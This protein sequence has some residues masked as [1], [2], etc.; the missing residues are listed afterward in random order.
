MEILWHH[1]ICR[2]RMKRPR[3]F[4]AVSCIVILVGLVSCSK[5]ETLEPYSSS[6]T[7][8]QPSVE[9]TGGLES[10]HTPLPITLPTPGLTGTP[11]VS[12][13]LPTATQSVVLSSSAT[14][15]STLVDWQAL[16]VIPALS[17]TA[18]QIYQL[19][20]TYHNNPNAFS[21]VGDC[22]TSSAYFLADFD[23]GSNAYNLGSYQDLQS[24][25]DYFSGSFGRVSLAAGK[26]YKAASVLNPLFADS[27]Q[28]HGDESPLICEYRLQKPS[29]AF[30]M[31]GTNDFSNSRT[32]F[33]GYMRQIIEYSIKNGVV[34]ILVTKADN[35]EGDN[36]INPLIAQLAIEYDVPLWNFW[37]AVQSI[38][39]QG[40]EADGAHLT[41]SK[42]NF[43]DPEAFQF[44]FPIRNLTALQVL[45][46]LLQGAQLIS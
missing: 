2:Q 5:T 3:F 32:A 21:K 14:P 23:L 18:L 24:V 30:I 38:P 22:E 8:I 13:D 35:L 45:Q 42:N 31:F 12:L 17:D 43:N 41:F 4:L 46:S 9:L 20:Q 40:L 28:C 25:I 11:D 37:A 36:S 39:N 27:S 16:P 1:S 26:G 19:G 10:T 34:P 6:A 44:A 29:F 33:E 15:E 7:V